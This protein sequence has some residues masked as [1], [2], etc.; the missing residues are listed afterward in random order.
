MRL[1]TIMSKHQSLPNG[2]CNVL[3]FFSFRCL[4]GRE[5]RS[6]AITVCSGELSKVS[7]VFMKCA[8]ATCMCTNQMKRI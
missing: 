3:F 6:R 5:L 7:A 4:G 1:I 8:T 2:V